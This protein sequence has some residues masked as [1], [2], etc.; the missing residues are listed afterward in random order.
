MSI[1]L[2]LT[3]LISPVK[4]DGLSSLTTCAILDSGVNYIRL[5]VQPRRG[6]GVWYESVSF[7]MKGKAYVIPLQ[8]DRETMN[9]VGVEYGIEE[10]GK[11]ENIQ[12][13]H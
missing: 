13:V 3:M 6:Q 10:C 11:V 2:F 5:D 4:A 1:F 9:F 12:Y 7:V 8:L